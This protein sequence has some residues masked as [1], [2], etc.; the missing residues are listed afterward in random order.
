[1]AWPRVRYWIGDTGSLPAV[2]AIE[3]ARDLI[4]AGA[5]VVM[6]VGERLR[7]GLTVRRAAR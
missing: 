3:L 5:S 1:M 6:L 7:G 4:D 2:D